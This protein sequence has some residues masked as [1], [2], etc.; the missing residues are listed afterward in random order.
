[1]NDLDRPCDSDSELRHINCLKLETAIPKETG[2]IWDK[3]KKISYFGYYDKKIEEFIDDKK[4]SVTYYSNNII[5]YEIV[6]DE[7]GNKISE[8]LSPELLII[9]NYLNE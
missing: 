6:W 7:N 5:K 1:M 4:K 8:Y 3:N 2:I 9:K